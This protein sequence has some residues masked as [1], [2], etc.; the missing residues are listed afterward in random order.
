MTQH[1]VTTEVRDAKPQIIE[2][3]DTIKEL[4]IQT[5]LT[6]PNADAGGR[7]MIEV[8]EDYAGRYPF[9]KVHK[10][11]PHRE[12]ISLMRIADVMVGNSSSGIIEAPSI[13]LPVVNIGTRQDG[14][15]RAEN[16]IDV[17]YHRQEIEE[18]IKI[19][20]YDEKFKKNVQECQNPYGQGTAAEIVTQ[21]LSDIKIDNRLINKRITY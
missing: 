19:A 3:L 9:I 16:V 7:S 1:P 5:I 20:L 11:I 4:G 18:G 14:R 12:Y 17:G 6:Y 2:T 8:I 13:K 10:S 21:I 15:E